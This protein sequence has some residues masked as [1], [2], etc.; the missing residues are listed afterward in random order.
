M[1]PVRELGYHEGLEWLQQRGGTLRT[2][3]LSI[4]AEVIAQIGDFEG[5]ARIAD[6]TE[7]HFKAALAEAINDLRDILMRSHGDPGDS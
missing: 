3:T 2:E 4:G 7:E 5:R 6:D 1:Y